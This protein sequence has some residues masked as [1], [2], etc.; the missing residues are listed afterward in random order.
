MLFAAH[1]NN[2]YKT[3][4]LHPNFTEI[5]IFV[6]EPPSCPTPA[7][8][9]SPSRPPSVNVTSKS[10]KDKEPN[11]KKKKGGKKEQDERNSKMATGTGEGALRELSHPSINE[12][13]KN[14]NAVT[15]KLVRTGRNTSFS[16]FHVALSD[17]QSTA[18]SSY[19]SRGEQTE[20]TTILRG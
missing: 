8:P 12:Q 1:S 15:F 16:I 7:S 14:H 3:S 20:P 9:P 2:N 4:Y 11:Q 6:S 18:V 19:F 13:L 5:W 10:K 17:I